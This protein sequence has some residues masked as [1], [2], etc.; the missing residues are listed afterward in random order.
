MTTKS[1]TDK[2]HGLV[3][4]YYNNQSMFAKT[5]FMG[6]GRRIQS[7]PQ[8][9]LLARSAGRSSRASSSS[10][11]SAVEPLRSSASTGNQTIFF[12]DQQFAALGAGELPEHVRHQDPEHLRAR[13]ARLSAA[14]P[15]PAADI[16]PG[17]CGTR[18][19]TTCRART[20]MIDS[21]IFNSSNFRDGDQ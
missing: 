15:R 20:A 8:Q 6:P 5:V 1:G 21:G 16:F 9:Q 17:T 14:S 19:P 2:F 4:D 13:P 18:P 3:S 12:P 11:S 7:V 10:S